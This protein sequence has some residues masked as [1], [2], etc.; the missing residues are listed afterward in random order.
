M[1]EVKAILLRYDDDLGAVFAVE[2]YE[3]Y[4]NDCNVGLVFRR[5]DGPSGPCGVDYYYSERGYNCVSDAEVAV[6]FYR[7]FCQ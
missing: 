7:N 2:D 1:N 6:Q 5:D 4:V 3:V